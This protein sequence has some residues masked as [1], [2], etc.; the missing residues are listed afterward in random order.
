MKLFWECGQCFDEIP[1]LKIQINFYQMNN[2]KFIEADDDRMDQ[3]SWYW[4]SIFALLTGFVSNALTFFLLWNKSY[5]RIF[6]SK[7]SSKT[8]RTSSTR[9]NLTVECWFETFESH[10]EFHDFLH[11]FVISINSWNAKRDKLLSEITPTQNDYT[12]QRFTLQLTIE[13]TMHQWTK[14]CK[15][16]EN[17]I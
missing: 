9:E 16:I 15:S 4:Y 10:T 13:I 5:S 12:W 7:T 6:F 11:F 8:R 2:R 17:E 3:I 1:S 14:R